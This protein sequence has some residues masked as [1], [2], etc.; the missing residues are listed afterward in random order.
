MTVG[1]AGVKEA[2]ADLRLGSGSDLC[3]TATPVV[4]GTVAGNNVGT[5]PD[6]AEASCVPDS[7]HDLWFA[8][9]ATCSASV[10]VE[11]DG[12]ALVP[13]NDTVV[14]VRETCLGAELACDNDSGPGLLSSLTFVAEAETS[15]LIRV[16]G[17]GQNVGDIQL[18]IRPL[19]ACAIDGTC[20]FTGEL[21][22]VNDCEVCLP[23]TST[24]DW[25]ARSKGADCGNPASSTCDSP[26]AC[27]GEGVCEPNHKPDGFPCDDGDSCTGSDGCLSGV[28]TGTPLPQPP[29]VVA[30]GPRI[31][32]VT[33][34]PAGSMLPIALRV[35]SPDYP[36]L[37]RWVAA[38]G[39][40]IGTP[41][42]Q[43]PE[44]WGTLR[45]ADANIVPET[46]YAIRSECGQHLSNP[47]LDETWIWGDGNHDGFVDVSDVLCVLDGFAGK[48]TSCSVDTIDL[49]PCESDGNIDVG[50]VLEIIDA[51]AG[52]G[53][54][55]SLPCVTAPPGP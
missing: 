54:P 53:Y 31:L 32:E 4:E 17:V 46:F 10:L 33:A 23:G 27:D 29:A 11:T 19:G 49:S 28:C 25:T 51:Y 39:T 44:D 36:C 3:A 38:N 18:T 7:N 8:Y 42:F 30:I 20:Y 55:C 15:Y 12:S 14:S 9:T 37:L 26:D 52:E 21:N 43:L 47:D 13:V 16:A 40:L 22:P 35:T 41:V 50:D 6:D 2:E 34:L 1:L 24:L 5:G 45:V 48:F